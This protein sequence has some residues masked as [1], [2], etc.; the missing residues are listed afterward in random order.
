TGSFRLAAGTRHLHRDSNFTEP[1][2]ETASKSLRHSC[3]SELTRQGISLCAVT[4]RRFPPSEFD[5]RRTCRRTGHFCR[6]L[7]V[8]AQH[9]PSHHPRGVS[10]VWSLRGQPDARVTSLL[11]F[12]TGRILTASN[13]GE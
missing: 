7:R 2:V 10:G 13:R 12:R 8:A 4:T 11:I 3:R 6:P 5:R 1:L 9:G